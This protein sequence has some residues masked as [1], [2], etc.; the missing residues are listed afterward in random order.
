[1]IL[2]AVLVFAVGTLSV[3]AASAAASGSVKGTVTWK[4]SKFVVNRNDNG[5]SS[6]GLNLNSLRDKDYARD[7]GDAGAKIELIPTG[8]DRNSIT[9]LQERTWYGESIPPAGKNIF[10]AIANN[11][12]YYEINSVPAGEYMLIIVSRKA[13]EN[14]TYPE[15]LMQRYIRDWDYFNSF[16]LSGNEYSMRK[17]NVENGKALTVNKN[18]EYTVRRGYV[19]TEK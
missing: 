6:G 9:E 8:F 5:M 2:S 14:Y 19:D 18:F 17:V 16:V 12:G 3:A 15:P 4:Y 11:A 7:R 10:V 13:R 1:M